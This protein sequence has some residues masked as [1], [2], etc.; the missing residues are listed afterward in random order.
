MLQF[1]GT[2]KAKHDYS[3][4]QSRM[5]F[6]EIHEDRFNWLTQSTA[7]IAER[8]FIRALKV[9]NLCEVPCSVMRDNRSAEA[10]IHLCFKACEDVILSSGSNTSNF[11][12][13]SLASGETSLQS[14]SLNSYLPDT[15]FRKSSF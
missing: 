13:K 3:I 7:I 10:F 11:C 14:A 5:C 12:T 1:T 15:I 4:D 6:F 2:K 9:F 8:S